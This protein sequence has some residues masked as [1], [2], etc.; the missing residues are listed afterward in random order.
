MSY[1]YSEIKNGRKL[2]EMTESEIAYVHAKWDRLCA[3]ENVNTPE[4]VF[5]QRANGFFFD[6]IRIREC[7]IRGRG[8]AGCHWNVR[9]GT[10]K[11]WKFAKDPFGSYYPEQTDKYFTGI[12]KESGEVI[13]VPTTVKAKKDVIELA[14]KLGWI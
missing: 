5:I 6:A 4:Q 13:Y 2:S 10:C 12:R 11:A 3:R 8:S 7:A 14:K 9:V 1:K